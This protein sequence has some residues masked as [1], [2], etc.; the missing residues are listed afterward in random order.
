MIYTRFRAFYTNTL[1]VVASLIL[2]LVAVESA[3]RAYLI[4]FPTLNFQSH[5]EFWKSKPL[6]YKDSNYDI[7]SFIDEASSLTNFFTPPNSRLVIPNDFKG[8]YINVE[9]G[10]RK[11]THQPPKFSNVIYVFGGST[12]FCKEVPDW[13]TLP[14][15]LQD[16]VNQSYPNQYKVENYGVSTVISAQELERLKTISLK[17]GDVVVFYNGAND[18]FMSIYKNN[19]EGWI[20]GENRRVLFDKGFFAT[21]MVKIHSRYSRFSKFVEFFL[22]PYD[23]RFEPTHLK[24][25]AQVEALASKMHSHYIENILSAY[26]YSMN[27]G[28][29]FFLFLQPTLVTGKSNSLYEYQL[30]HNPYLTANGIEKAMLAGYK[31]LRPAVRKL[32]NKHDVTTFDMSN[33]FDKRPQGAEYFLDWVHVSEKGNARIANAIFSAIKPSLQR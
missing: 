5:I 25:E 9:N 7:P 29:K 33:L 28:S 15:L 8:R 27:S 11:T 16:L 22:S 10:I 31:G 32:K 17:P 12:V 24:K 26:H 3:S 2:V 4:F 13:Y 23:Y 30:S 20:I 21:S 6:P 19:P 14:S 1:L 18:S